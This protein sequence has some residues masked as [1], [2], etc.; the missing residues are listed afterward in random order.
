MAIPNR[1]TPVLVVTAIM[2][3][4]ASVFVLLR[5]ISRIFI[6]HRVSW[7]DYFIC[8]AW[9]IS[10]GMSF[11]IC[12]GTKVGLGRH[13]TDV[14]SEWEPSLKKAEYAFSV[15]YVSYVILLL[16][17]TNPFQNPALIAT[18]TSILMFYLSISK[19]NKIFR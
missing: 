16:T 2:L 11:A 5:M 13:E 4:L 19:G 8:L 12:Y 7:D 15:L 17:K 10:F 3:I 18:K 9:I 14:P 1:G 6:V